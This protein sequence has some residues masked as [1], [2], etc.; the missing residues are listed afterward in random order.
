[1]LL[2]ENIDDDKYKRMI[3]PIYVKNEALKTSN[4][5]NTFMDHIWD[6]FYT[7]Q[8]R[9]SRWPAII[10]TGPTMSYEVL[11]TGTP[12]GNQRFTLKAD[13]SA[14]AMKIN[15]PKPGAYQIL[16]VNRK[17]IPGNKWNDTLKMVNPLK[18]AYCGENKYTGVVNVLEFYLTAGCTLYVQPID[19]IVSSIRMKWTLDEFYA[20][21]G[22]TA[23]VDRMASS[24]GIHAADIKV[25]SVY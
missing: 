12:P 9:L 15:Y 11:Y 4:A 16:D 7:G 3:T 17:V 14:V 20:D 19:A 6:G 21:G 2:F 18:N 10:Q 5:I 1:M 22:S 24:L 8:L 23:F 13:Y 25:V